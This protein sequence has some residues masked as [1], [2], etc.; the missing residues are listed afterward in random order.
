MLKIVNKYLYFGDQ[1]IVYLRDILTS[2]QLCV[3][4]IKFIKNNLFIDNLKVEPALRAK[5]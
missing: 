5:F 3:S 2:S 4:F 1:N